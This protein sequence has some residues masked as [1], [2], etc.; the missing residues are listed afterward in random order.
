MYRLNYYTDK[1]ALYEGNDAGAIIINSSDISQRVLSLAIPKG[2]MTAA[3]RAAIETAR[4]RAYAF[5]IELVV[6]PF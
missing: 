1:L 6:T 3:Q 2:S 4:L 5:D